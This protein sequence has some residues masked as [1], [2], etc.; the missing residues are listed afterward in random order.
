MGMHL[1]LFSCASRSSE[2]WGASGTFP[3]FL[4]TCAA[5]MNPFWRTLAL[6]ILFV[7]PAFPQNDSP[8]VEID[9]EAI[10][11]EKI[12]SAVRIS[13]SISLDGRLD[14]PAWALASPAKD[15]IQWGPR[16]G[17]PATEQ[18]DVR[19]LYDDD[20]LYVGVI[21]FDSDPTNLVISGLQEDFIFS[22]S[23]NVALVLDSL[24]DRR[25]GFLFGV[26]PAG[27]KRD[28]QI[29]N[30]GQ[31]NNDWDA[32]WDAKTTTNDEGWIA[33]FVIPFKTLRFSQSPFQEWGVNMSRFVVRKS[34]ESEWSPLPVRYRVSRISQAGTL[35][36][37][38]GIRQGR[39][40]KVKPFVTAGVT[41]VRGADGQIQ[42]LRSLKKAKDYDGGFDAKYSLTPSLTL[43][44]TYRTDFA[45]VEVDQQQVNLT[46]FNLFFPEKREFFL[47]NAGTFNFGGGRRGANL[48]P[49]FS[50]TIGLDRGTPI[51]IVGGARVSGQAGRYDVGFLTMK[52]ESF[53]KKTEEFPDGQ[54][55][56][57]N[58]YLVGRIKRNFSTSSWIGALVTNRDST[59]PGDYNRVYGADMHF[60]FYDRLE[61]DSYL[62]RS[63]TP[64]KSGKDQARKFRTEWRDDELVIG[65]EYNSVQTNFNPQMGFIR[66]KDVTQY[67]GN[68]SW[69]PRLRGSRTIRNLI[70]TTNLDYYEGG[71]GKVETRTQDVDLGI[72]FLDNG[73]INFSINEN[74]DRLVDTFLIRADLPIAPGD[75]RYREYSMRFNTNQARRFSGSGNVSVGEFWDGHRKSFGGS[76]GLKPDHHLNVDLD[77]RYDRVNLPNGSFTTSLVGARFLY[78]FTPR[79]ILKAF[80]QYNADTHQLSSNIRFNVIHHPLSDLYL[81][82]NDRRSTDT[83][84]LVERAFIVK[85]TNL[86]SF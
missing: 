57:S 12:V 55:L 77:Y 80:F 53:T 15:F 76:L 64:G 68:F 75:Y 73:R 32:V 50:R 40:L 61:F 60:Q 8:T 69:L 23:D 43:D 66:R 24:H 3:R 17:E 21:C 11:L 25:S 19:F 16:P 74:F 34:E 85:L 4:L 31:F 13:E 44:A 38:E 56:P 26:N 14:E 62:L 82:Y 36:G 83:G 65:A 81:V 1:E 54:T 39:N 71:N 37:L 45:Q 7:L 27:A 6:G 29:S 28:S 52:T 79:A 41:Q 35:I 46:R 67:S 20:N 22:Q 70:F 10:R 33:E 78:G 9:Y 59:L 18:T 84:Q 42:T 49:F 86:I 72:Q 30:N 63:E 48:V 58:N 51:P 5:R 47:E 2:T